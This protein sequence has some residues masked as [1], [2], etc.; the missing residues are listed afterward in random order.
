M[1]TTNG[2]SAGTYG[3]DFAVA[4]GPMPVMRTSEWFRTIDP[5]RRATVRRLHD[6]RPVY[7]LVVI[8]A[9]I[10]LWVLTGWTMLTVP[11]WSVRIAGYCLIGAIIHG[12]AVMMHEG[13]HGNLLRRP[14]IDRWLGFVLGLPGTAC[15]S[16]YRVEHIAHHRFTRTTQDP[17]EIRNF[18]SNR[19][20]LSLAFYLWLFGGSLW[21]FLVYVPINALRIGSRRDRLAILLEYAIMAGVYAAF[22]WFAYRRGFAADLVHVWMIPI[23]VALFY[24]NIRGWAEHMMTLP[25]HPLTETRTV[26]SNPVVCFL[27][28]NAN[29]HL[30][31]HLFPAVPWYNLPKVHA[32]FADDFRRAGAFTYRSYLRFVLDAFRTGVHGLAPKYRPAVAMISAVGV[33]SS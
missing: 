16:A 31:H 7:N 2:P 28:L 17:D 11:S 6:V 13:V 1:E 8:V 18:S 9:F 15:F 30:E 4:R 5:S 27:N 21:Y 24:G 33:S 14:R 20:L 29:Y 3:D 12:L 26:T 10:G 23:L 25:G 19:A 32:L 22:G